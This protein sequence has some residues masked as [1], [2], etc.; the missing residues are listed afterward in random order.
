MSEEIMPPL[1]RWTTVYATSG[2]AVPAKMVCLE[3]AEKYAKTRATKAVERERQRVLDILSRHR[4][5]EEKS[6]NWSEEDRVAEELLA[7]LQMDVL[8]PETWIE[9]DK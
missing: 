7:E 9:E 8:E 3:A 4:P 1:E 2:V 5:Y 6:I